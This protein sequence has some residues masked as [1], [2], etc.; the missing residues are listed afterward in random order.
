M[1][2]TA[3]NAANPAT[4]TPMRPEQPAPAPTAGA[5]RINLTPEAAEPDYLLYCKGVGVLPRRGINTLLGKTKSGKSAAAGILVAAMLTGELQGFS[6]ANKYPLKVLMADCEQSRAATESAVRNIHK[7]ANFDPNRNHPALIALNL[8]G[9]NREERMN[10]IR[11]EM[12]SFNPDFVLIDGAE[13]LFR[14]PGGIQGSAEVCEALIEMAETHQCAVLNVLNVP[15]RKA[16]EEGAGANHIEALFTQ[17]STEIYTLTR[18]GTL[19]AITT[20]SRFGDKPP[21][22]LRPNRALAESALEEE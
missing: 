20:S 4:G 5:Y 15:T 10:I 6:T 16:D 17:K 8:S 2:R 21:M 1:E 14:D 19:T 7:A 18:E 11:A 13:R 9:C 12:E 3:N 22:V